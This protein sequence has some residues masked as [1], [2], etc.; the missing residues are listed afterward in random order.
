MPRAGIADDQGSASIGPSSDKEKGKVVPHI[1]LSDTEVSSEEDDVP[2]IEEDEAVP[3][4][5]VHC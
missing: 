5:W 4:W 1:V 3:Q 2:P